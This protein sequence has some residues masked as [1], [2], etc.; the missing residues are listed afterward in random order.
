VRAGSG[1]ATVL[2]FMDRQIRTFRGSSVDEFGDMSDVGSPLYTGIQAA[3]AEVDETVFD[4]ATQRMSTIRQVKGVVPGWADI[5]AS[6]TL[7][8]E[9]T[10]FYY[11]VESLEAEPGIGFYPPRKL[12]TLRERSGVS[13]ASD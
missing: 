6:D 13:I 11:M 7:Q 10:G 1:G 5:I 2:K 12:L 3:I 9:F 8:D 4:A